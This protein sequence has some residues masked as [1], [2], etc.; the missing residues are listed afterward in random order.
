MYRYDSFDHLITAERVAQFRDQV[1][2]RL[3]GE[4]TEDEFRVLRLQN[5]LYMQIH[6]YMLR[7]AVP[8]GL[9]SAAQM[10]MFA[11]IARKYDRGYGHFTTRQNIQFNWLKLQDAP[12]VLADLATVEMHANQTSGNCIRNITSDEFAGVARDEIV[13]PRPYAEILRQWST[14]HPEF[15]Y[16]PRKFKFAITGASDDRAAIAV[17]DIGLAVVKNA[18]GEVGFRVLVGGGLGRTPVIGVEICDFVPWQHIITYAESIVRVY[19]EYGRRDNIY[20]AR[21]KIL[22]KALGI[23]EFKRQVEADWQFTKN[24]PC[25]ITQAELDRV[26]AYFTAPA[27]ERLP[28]SDAAVEALQR[29]NKAFFNWMRRN[30]KPHKVPGYAAVM[31]SLKKTGI[32]PGDATDHQMD[33]AAELAE[34]FSFGELR[35]TH[36][37]NL[38]LAD[39]KQSDL[40]ELWEAAKKLGMATAN[41]GLLTDMICCPG[42]DFCSLANARSIPLAKAIAECFDDIDFQHDIG[43]LEMN[44]SGCIN[45]CG[46][47]HVGHI[48]ILGV[49]KD[50]E[51]WYQVQIGG[52]QG[53]DARL[54]KVIGR[55]FSFEQ[56]PEVIARLLQVYVRER[57]D[58]ER[59]IDTVRRLGVDPFKAE[60]YGTP[61]EADE[62]LKA[63]DYDLLKQGVAYSMPYYSPRF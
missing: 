59:F 18:Q 40:I 14:F 17:H 19:N 44:I 32:A 5:G 28:E 54:G 46:H 41:I 63:P 39:V 9:V 37:Q 21:I 50:G 10:R 57:F 23:E 2:R 52:A 33:A 29:D 4:L 42:G 7:I 49:D 36:M 27:Y 12:D 58:D 53:N 26:S 1:R 25:T 47:H 22:V 60:V 3:S 16:L 62:E 56:M 15:A 8:Y 51:E 43:E 24:G 35:I 61:V 31:L 11:H 55:S 30:V 20:K 48:G 38:V 34:R 45:A 6:A 13:D